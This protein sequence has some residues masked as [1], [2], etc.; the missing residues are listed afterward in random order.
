MKTLPAALVDTSAQAQQLSRL[1]LLSKE[2]VQNNANASTV[3]GHE[4]DSSPLNFAQPQLEVTSKM[5]V[6][7]SLRQRRG[8][9]WSANV[10]S[11]TLDIASA[12][13]KCVNMRS[14]RSLKNVCLVAGLCVVLGRAKRKKDILKDLVV[15]PRDEKR[16]RLNWN[17]S[18]AAAETNLCVCPH[19][20]LRLQIVTNTN[21]LSEVD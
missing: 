9:T 15:K 1:L 20:M 8:H 12:L 17:N 6:C 7:S 2:H 11:A 10:T 14:R 4:K 3:V 19:W 16:R 5:H 18:S 21:I 13:E